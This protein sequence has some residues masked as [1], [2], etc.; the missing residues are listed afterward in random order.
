MNR[1]GDG[2]PHGPNG[3]GRPDGARDGDDDR[4][5]RSFARAAAPRPAEGAA[6]LAA[7]KV[8]ASVAAARRPGADPASV[9]AR[10]VRDELERSLGRAATPG[11]VEQVTGALLARPE[12]RQE[13]LELLASVPNR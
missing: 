11:L 8:R 3:P 10:V 2:G 6:R 9:A 7:S 5:R 1:I 12:W 13:F 4:V